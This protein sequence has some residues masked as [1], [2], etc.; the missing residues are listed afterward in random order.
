MKKCHLSIILITLFCNQS[1]LA[2]EQ[3]ESSKEQTELNQQLHDAI[4]INSVDEL[5]GL[6]NRGAGINNEY[7]N[8]WT[9]LMFGAFNC[10]SEE[11]IKELLFTWK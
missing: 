4:L 1:V 2:K 5:A 11:T 3:T 7:R 8:K 9:P 6:V 10:S